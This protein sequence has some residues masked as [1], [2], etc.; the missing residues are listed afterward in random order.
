MQT[1]VALSTT[2]AEYIALA[3]ALREFIPMR[4]A[5]E[6]MIVAFDLTKEYPI[7]VKS[8]I[9][10]DNNGAIS[11]ATTPKMSSRT[12]HI[13]VKYHFVKDYFAKKRNPDHHPFDLK[14]IATE[15]QKADVF[16]KGLSEITFHRI[17]KR[18]NL[19]SFR[20]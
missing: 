4:H 18:R 20:A 13:G 12:K 3:Q 11:T 5:F 7:T 8:T 2:E 10:E 9:F 15:D 19:Q 14:K 17:R 6:D 16:T 1:E